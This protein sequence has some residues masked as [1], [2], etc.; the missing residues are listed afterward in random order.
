MNGENIGMTRNDLT[1]WIVYWLKCDG[2]QSKIV[3]KRLCSMTIIE[4]RDLESRGFHG[5]DAKT[6][7]NELLVESPSAVSTSSLASV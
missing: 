5:R 4:L 6:L 3:H 7:L 1:N 2:T